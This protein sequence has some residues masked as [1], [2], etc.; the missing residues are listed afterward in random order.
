MQ[1]H[2]GKGHALS[3]RG[4]AT[5]SLTNREMLN[6]SDSPRPTALRLW[7][8]PLINEGGQGACTYCPANGDL[9]MGCVNS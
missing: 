9:T 5:N 6:D 2:V 4:V 8:T 7:G 3:L 1:R